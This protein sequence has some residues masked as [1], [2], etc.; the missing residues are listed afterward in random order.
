MNGWNGNYCLDSIFTMVY[1][2]EH[3]SDT[4]KD[5]EQANLFLRNFLYR[6]LS[7]E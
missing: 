6:R 1:L 2:K 7:R 5:D 4:A 3:F